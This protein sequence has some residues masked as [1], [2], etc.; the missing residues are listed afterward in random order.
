MEKLND[1]AWHQLRAEEV[2]QFLSVD[3][4]AGLSSAEVPGAGPQGM[5]GQSG[6][7]RRGAAGSFASR[8]LQPG[9]TLRP[10]P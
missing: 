5:G 1:K 10:L 7:R 3:L 9:G 8:P 2:V 6:K 4:A